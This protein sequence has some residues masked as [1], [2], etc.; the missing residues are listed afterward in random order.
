MIF[1]HRSTLFLIVIVA[2]TPFFCGQACQTTR[3]SSDSVNLIVGPLDEFSRVFGL[4]DDKIFE[5]ARDALTS[6][7]LKIDESST[8]IV[9]VSI[10]SMPQ[11]DED[12]Y[13]FKIE[14]HGG[15][16]LEA[17]EGHKN[18]PWV[19]GDIPQIKMVNSPRNDDT[20][21]LDAVR[22]LTRDVGLKLRK[23]L[24]K[25]RTKNN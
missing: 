6:N 2:L 20:K 22:Q 25:F 1:A 4:H 8:L 16:S 3:S 9:N 24:L 19:I 23:E 13:P 15:T 17:A 10:V 21:I 5:S 14:V 18:E 7:G 12:L 11:T